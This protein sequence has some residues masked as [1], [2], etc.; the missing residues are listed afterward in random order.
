M[1]AR[2]RQGFRVSIFNAKWRF[3]L[4]KSCQN[5]PIY[6]EQIWGLTGK[7]EIHIHYTMKEE[8]NGYISFTPARGASTE[9]EP[10]WTGKGFSPHHTGLSILFRLFY[11]GCIQCWSSC[12][13]WDR[14]ILAYGPSSTIS[15]HLVLLYPCII[16]TQQENSFYCVLTFRHSIMSQEV[17]FF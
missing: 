1:S 12:R 17:N 16:C 9:Y 15:Y 3:N 5:P 11:R 7:A 10:C 8:W 4:S 13:G 6:V 2:C 14:A